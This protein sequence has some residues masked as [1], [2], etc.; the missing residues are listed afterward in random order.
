MLEISAKT[1]GVLEQFSMNQLVDMAEIMNIPLSENKME[2]IKNMQEADVI[3]QAD[4]A[5]AYR[6][7]DL[8]S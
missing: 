6:R 2:L 5:R 8:K 1:K 7:D 4:P 3:I